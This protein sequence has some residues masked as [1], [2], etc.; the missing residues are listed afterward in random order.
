MRQR[1]GDSL[2]LLLATTGFVLL[3]ACA[4]LANLLLA[5]ASAREQ[6]MAV[7]LAI[8]A[9]RRRL[10]RQLLVES[11]LLALIGAA[12]GLVVARILSD[13]LVAAL[14]TS[15]APIFVNLQLDWRVAGFTAGLALATC[16]LFGI[17]PALKATRTSPAVAI[18][19]DGRGLSASRDRFILRRSLVVVQIALSLVLLLG[20]LLFART[21]YNLLH[22]DMGFST[23][24]VV[25]ASLN[26]RR[27]DATPERLPL[28]R[29]SLLERI[30]AVPGV[31]VAD[32][33]GIVPISGDFWND[34]L[35]VEGA[36]VESRPTVVNFSRVGPAYF[37][38]LRIPF[39]AGRNFGDQDRPTSTPVAVVNEALVR[40][41][42][43]GGSPIGWR[44]RVD[45]APGESDPVYEIVG[46]VG[47]TKYGDLREKFG[48]VVYLPASQEARP[49][50]GMAVV[51]R[52]ALPADRIVPA[53]VRAVGEEHPA[54][55]LELQMMTRQ[56]RETLT[57]ERLMALLSGGFGVLATSM[58]MLGL[59]GVMS[60]IAARRRHEI[61]IR[62][63]LGAERRD[64]V[65]MMISDTTRLLIVGLACG[66][67][68]A[69]AA[70]GA[71]RALL[72]GL[73]PGDPTT[74]GLAI[75]ALSAAVLFAAYLPAARASRLDPVTA[76]RQE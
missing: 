31:E 60:Y 1:F 14:S 41:Q 54:I 73:D 27:M 68:L 58:A 18:R 33:A 66:T 45:A 2:I 36:G 21:L 8:G 35:R 5:R 34:S 59:Y 67:A 63:A 7:R 56:V 44:V 49:G 53:I 64:V 70:G 6:E 46:V 51:V 28:V 74:I 29:R 50:A 26:L 15:Q 13:A 62:L 16:L 40:T 39:V 10:V 48:P 65:R 38:A 20:S 32:H 11:L 75:A 22:A 61:G 47:D 69:F 76:L 30:R 12:I 72:F 43:K 17:A 25:V 55:G 9:S 37:H 4:N 52:S 19:A 24:G 3:I 57:R 71:A 23:D 42:M